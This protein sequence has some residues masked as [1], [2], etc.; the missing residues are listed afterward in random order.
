MIEAAVDQSQERAAIMSVAIRLTKITVM[1]V[2][3]I[4]A[5]P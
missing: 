2:N 3:S 1:I 4:T 5:R